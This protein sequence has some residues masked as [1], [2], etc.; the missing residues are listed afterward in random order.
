[1][2]RFKL[3]R[4]VGSSLLLC[5]TTA[6]ASST[7]HAWTTNGPLNSTATAPATLFQV[8]SSPPVGV[9]CTGVS[10]PGNTA[11][12][13]VSASGS[14]TPFNAATMDLQFTGCTAAGWSMYVSCQPAQLWL[15]SYTA[16]VSTG[17]TRNLVCT[18][19]IPSMPGCTIVYTG[20]GPNSRAF[21][22]TYDNVTHRLTLL[23]PTSPSAQQQ[24]LGA[25]WTAGCTLFA[26]RPGSASARWSNLSNGSPV[27][28]MT[29]S[30]APTFT[31]P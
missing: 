7:A 29:S 19:T 30:P 16:P 28:T 9:S 14:T 27:Y 20:T 2:R 15:S 25:T 5:C 13:T 8:N 3:L 1:M 10:A 21:H 12:G 11:T 24:T 31:N 18:K 26:T 17:E 23:N 6:A 4:L 22:V